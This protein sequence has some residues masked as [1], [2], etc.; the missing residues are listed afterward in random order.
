MKKSLVIGASGLVGRYLLDTLE[1]RGVTVQGTYHKNPLPRRVPLDA[2]DTDALLSLVDGFAPEIVYY[3][4]ANPNVEWIESEPEAAYAV[5]VA[6]VKQLAAHLARNAPKT[7]L[8]Y[9]STDYVFDGIHGPYTETDTP[10][11]INEY[12]RQKW[13]CE[14][15]VQTLP[16]HIVFRVTVVYGWEPPQAKNYVHRTVEQLRR[17]VSAPLRVPSDQVGNPSYAPNLAAAAIEIAE[18]HAVGIYNL[19]G[20]ERASR[21]DFA[22]A[23]ARTWGFEESVFTPVTTDALHQKAA[24]PLNAGMDVSKAQACLSGD[25]RLQGFSDALM[26]M[27]REEEQ[28]Q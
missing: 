9:Y 23:I 8:V 21:Y 11:P 4:A 28:N 2:T 17:G 13:E 3:P 10:C 1:A 27:K 7:R 25:N 14:R 6:P 5:N 16:D 26:V 20:T 15:I 22:R 19:A 18:N 12:G 24:R